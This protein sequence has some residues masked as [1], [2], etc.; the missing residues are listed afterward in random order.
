MKKI[1]IY[2]PLFVIFTA[3]ACGQSS[4]FEDYHSIKNETWCRNDVAEFNAEIPVAGRYAL[5]LCLRHTTDYELANL[6]CFLTTWGPA[7]LS[8]RDTV[9]IKMAEPDGRWIG[10]GSGIKTLEQPINP[11]VIELPQGNITFRLEQGMRTECLKGVKDIGIKITRL[12][13]HD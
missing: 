4:V 13:T 2:L 8:F 7:E 12:S 5:S 1:K 9:N 3:F 10:Q 11:K 6:W